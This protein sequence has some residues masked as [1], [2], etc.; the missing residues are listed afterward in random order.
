MGKTK[1]MARKA[2]LGDAAPLAKQI[3]QEASE[4]VRVILDSDKVELATKELAKIPKKGAKKMV[5]DSC[6]ENKE[7]DD[8]VY[9]ESR[10]H[11]F[12]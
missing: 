9:N 8:Q 6:S 3:K 1:L 12:N 4:S 2:S 5:E 7:L 10:V 11:L